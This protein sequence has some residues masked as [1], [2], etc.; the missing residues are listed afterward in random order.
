MKT[1]LHLPTA[2]GPRSAL[3]LVAMLLGVLHVPAAALADGAKVRAAVESVLA[4]MERAVLAGDADAYLRHVATED[5]VFL[6]EKKM[7]A[8]DL[9]RHVP[10]TFR[11]RIVD[12][13]ERA[14]NEAAS[15]GAG[16]DG[17]PAAD[18]PAPD[19]PK[20]EADRPHEFGPTRAVFELEMKWKM[21]VPR[22]EGE[23]GDPRV[24]DRTVSYPVVFALLPTE[25]APGGRWLYK[26]EHWIEVRAEPGD[27]A[28]TNHAHRGE[29]VAMCFAGYEDVS[30]RVVEMLPEIRAH[31]DT[32]F[33]QDVP[34]E[35][36]VKIYPTMQHL[37][38]SI[39]LSYWDGLSG[40]N[41]PKESIKII[42]RPN[43]RRQ[44]LQPLLAHE[45]GHVVTFEMGPQATDIDWWVLEGVAELAAEAYSS[46][47]AARTEQQVLRWAAADKLAEFSQI[48]DFRNTHKEVMGH[49]YRQGQHMS[50]YI[51]QRFG[52]TKR[53][54]WLRAMANGASID[55]AS[56][57]ELGVP[58]GFAE[59]DRDW[60]SDVMSRVREE[61][62]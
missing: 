10:E 38:A 31:V 59:I 12:P 37:Q 41:E 29:N 8:A 16:R 6:Q 58:G 47:S 1:T 27:D 21:T 51:T 45:Y 53:N 30:R 48:S 18:A 39:Y 50:A 2:P 4:E 46:N 43:A 3:F 14:A 42:V 34:H 22:A 35:Q 61:E 11:L 28:E 9:R 55:E 49:V 56:V 25:D 23:A 57:K 44:Q 13:A 60:R 20:A 5:A 15:R 24:I 40:W 19:G 32:G 26:G 62:P 36:V 33:E 52:R 17:A 7:W 54:N